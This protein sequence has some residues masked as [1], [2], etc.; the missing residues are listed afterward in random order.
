MADSIQVYKR[1]PE[2]DRILTAVPRRSHVPTKQT[3]QNVST[4][5][6][7]EEGGMWQCSVTRFPNA[8]ATEEDE[9]NWYLDITW[10]D[11]T[12]TNVVGIFLMDVTWIKRREEFF[13]YYNYDSEG[14]LMERLKIDVSRLQG[15]MSVFYSV[16][17][18][19]FVLGSVDDPYYPFFIRVATLSGE[20]VYDDKGERNIRPVVKQRLNSTVE[21]VY[22]HYIGPFSAR[23]SS[24]GP[25]YAKCFKLVESGHRFRITRGT[26]DIIVNIKPGMV[27]V[28]NELVG[29]FGHTVTLTQ[30]QKYIVLRIN[31]TKNTARF[32][33]IEST[34]EFYEYEK[35]KNYY[36]YGVA[37]MWSSINW[38]GGA[39]D[40]DDGETPVLFQVLGGDLNIVAERNPYEGEFALRVTSV[41][42]DEDGNATATNVSVS[43]GMYDNSEYAGRVLWGGTLVCKPLRYETKITKD[44][45]KK[46]IWLNVSFGYNSVYYGYS[47]EE[48]DDPTELTKKNA[49]KDSF[50]YWWLIG[51]VNDNKAHQ[52]HYYGPVVI[53]DRLFD[54]TDEEDEEEKSK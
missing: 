20:W 39:S 38:F 34:S 53:T 15:A 45:K 11:G 52:A 24:V 3:V 32:E 22:N 10:P 23:I 13:A 18:C 26:G 17:T 7:D 54:V 33:T 43:N 50:S 30:K 28:N 49:D 16:L 25:K 19:E 5:R 51:Y 36:V 47:V 2:R 27:W 8:E 29:K 21:V 1:T 6:E 42:Y 37:G 35:D 31:K 40:I 44:S 48:S 12:L 41:E 4:R 9:N 14:K 46:Y